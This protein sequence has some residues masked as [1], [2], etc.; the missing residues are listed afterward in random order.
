M[1][2]I[3]YLGRVKFLVYSK[4]KPNRFHIKMFMVS[5]HET[6]YICGFSVYTGRNSNELLADKCTLDPDCTVTTRTVMALLQRN[7]L[8]D[9]HR[10]VYF[11][12]WFTSCQLLSELRYRDTYAAGTVCQSCR[13]LPK[14]VTSKTVKLKKGESVFRRN[15]Y[16]LCLKWC[17]K[18]PVTFLSS[19]HKAVE[20][21]VKINYL[22]QPIIKPVVVQDYNFRMNSV[23]HTDHFLSNYNT[24]KSIKWYRKLLLH[25]IN[26]VT[27]NS[28][29]LNKKYGVTKLSHTAYREYIANYLITTSLDQAS[30]IKTRIP[31]PLNNCTLRL[32]GRHFISKLE[33]QP[34]AKRVVPSRKCKCCNFTKEQLAHY[35]VVDTVLKS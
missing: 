21:L 13:G 18:R 9:E 31:V 7:N 27:L 4:A 24:L 34:G 25:L 33:P 26:M 30:C 19:K 22:G 11:D 12:N 20:S 17:D 8:L 10:T 15:D 29:I 6:G 3:A 14:A 5:E 1:F 35:G 23:D 16:M 32:T 2:I 28:Y